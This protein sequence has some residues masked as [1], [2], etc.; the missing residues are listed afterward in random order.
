ML[1]YN[2]QAQMLILNV[3]LFLEY[4]KKPF[5]DVIPIDY[6]NVYDRVSQALKVSTATLCRMKK[7]GI[8]AEDSYFTN[9]SKKMSVSKTKITAFMKNKEVGNVS[10]SNYYF[11]FIVRSTITQHKINEH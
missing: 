1:R 3:L 2:E 6:S 5:S 9:I 7:A 8:Q 11:R 10:M 4:E